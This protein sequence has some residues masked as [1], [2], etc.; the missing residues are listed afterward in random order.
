M[1]A[2]KTPRKLENRSIYTLRDIDRI[3]T[4]EDG[5]ICS[6]SA[7]EAIESTRQRNLLLNRV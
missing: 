1:G 4:S 6:A 2:N 5:Q 7:I 3:Q